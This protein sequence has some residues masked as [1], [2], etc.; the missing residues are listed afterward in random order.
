M[1]AREKGGVQGEEDADQLLVLGWM[2]KGHGM[3]LGPKEWDCPAGSSDTHFFLQ[4]I[5]DS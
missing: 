1:P 4:S 5:F 2:G 3:C